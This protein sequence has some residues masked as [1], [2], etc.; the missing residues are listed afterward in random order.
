MGLL[1]VFVF[2]G[3]CFIGFFPETFYKGFHRVF[4]FV[5]LVGFMGLTGL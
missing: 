2:L 5:G 3:R 1:S 4:G